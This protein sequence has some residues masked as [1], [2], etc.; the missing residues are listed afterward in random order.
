M[1][2][3]LSRRTMLQGSGVAMALPILECMAGS[4]R[5]EL[6]L[7]KP[8]L[9]VA[10]MFKPNGVYPK[11]WTPKRKNDDSFDTEPRYLKPFEKVRDEMI[12][13][14][15]FWHRKTVGRNGHWPKSPCLAFRRLCPADNWTRYRYREHFGGSVDGKEAGCAHSVA[16]D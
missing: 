2:Q 8:P 13:L 16:F 5:D 9:R 3:P 10:F 7:D 15:N 11:S 12:L 6:Q 4:N 14:E 1:R